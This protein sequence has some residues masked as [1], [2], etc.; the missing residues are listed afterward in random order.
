MFYFIPFLVL[1]RN[2]TLNIGGNCREWIRG[3]GALVGDKLYIFIP[4]MQ[5]IPQYIGNE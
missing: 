4:C 2:G 3:G 1:G 5:N